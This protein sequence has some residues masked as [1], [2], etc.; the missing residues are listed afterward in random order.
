MKT[1]A[2]TLLACLLLAGTAAIAD[3]RHHEAEYLFARDAFT[4]PANLDRKSVV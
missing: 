2:R 1:L 3:W 4:P